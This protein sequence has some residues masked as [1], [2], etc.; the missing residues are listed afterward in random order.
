ML[1]PYSCYARKPTNNVFKCNFSKT[2]RDKKIR[3][4]EKT[5]KR[6]NNYKMH[7]NNWKE[8]L[9]EL[10]KRHKIKSPKETNKDRKTDAQKDNKRLKGSTVT[11]NKLK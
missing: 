5:K 7:N 11:Q 8:K 4:L 3:R 10:I 2:K 9:R 1:K 6:L